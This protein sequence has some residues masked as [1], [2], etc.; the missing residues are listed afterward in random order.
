MNMPPMYVIRNKNDLS[1][2]WSNEFGWVDDGGYDLFTE[3]EKEKL[4]LPIE[5]VWYRKL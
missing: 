1:L 4:N 5:G 2:A 3:S